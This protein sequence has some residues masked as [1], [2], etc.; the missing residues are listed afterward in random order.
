[1]GDSALQ[2]P[3]LGGSLFRRPTLTL[4]DYRLKLDPEVE[5]LM[6]EFR[7][8]RFTIRMRRAWLNPD[9]SALDRDATRDTLL[10]FTPPTPA[11]SCAWRAPGRG[12]ETPRPGTVGDVMTAVYRVPCVRQF[13]D[14]HLDR[15]ERRARLIWDGASTG[16]RV[17]IVAGAIGVVGAGIALG[18]L[19]GR[20]LPVPGI[21]GLSATVSLGMDAL[22]P[23]APPSVAEGAFSFGLSM[24]L[25]EV[26]DILK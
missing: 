20:E 22:P 19:S 13:V 12:P 8:A 24:D 16:S 18:P 5:A 14:G 9:W 25:A 10:N 15:V 21:P 26:I 23:G 3:E 4:G 7:A 2:L 1:M 11:A 17:S 6:A